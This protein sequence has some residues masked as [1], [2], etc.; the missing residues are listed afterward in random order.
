MWN[1]DSWHMMPQ[2]WSGG[3]V[4]GI[5]WLLVL[6]LLIVAIVYAV[7]M[8]GG[9]EFAGG[10]SGEPPADRESPRETLDRRYAE[11]ELS[12][13]EYERMKSDLEE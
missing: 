11:G 7:R 6:V 2:N 13:E 12:R 3:V 9:R 10:P 1:H 8:A 5:F 4:M